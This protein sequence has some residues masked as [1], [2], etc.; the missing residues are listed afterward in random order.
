MP[1]AARLIRIFQPSP[2]GRSVQAMLPSFYK[3]WTAPPESLP[4]IYLLAVRERH[5]PNGEP[6]QWIL[7]ERSETRLDRQDGST[8]TA[9]IRLSFKPL[10]LSEESGFGNHEAFNGNYS[11]GPG[12]HDAEISITGG[13]LMIRDRRL[14][15]KRIG[16]HLMNEVVRWA[17]QWPTAV[18]SE[19]SVSSVDDYLDK[20]D[21]Q[22]GQGIENKLR[23]NL[24]YENFG[25]KMI[26]AD[27]L[28]AEGYSLPMLARELI[29]RD[30]WKQNIEVRDVPGYI[31]ELRN[32]IAAWTQKES[33]RSR[34]IEELE[35]QIKSAKRSPVLW[36]CHQVGL[37][38]CGKAPWIA[39]LGLI[40]L[41]LWV[42]FS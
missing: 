34:H 28:K 40:I 4:R 15:S 7:V 37:R 35:N 10:R 29:P 21:G 22:D 31:R 27:D 1:P 17:Q 13:S 11:S 25:L 41:L 39:L 24:L 20:V 32:D 5:L 18:V 30:T 23:R 9:S 2:V 19:V 3:E 14:Q 38:L 6:V 12:G 42:V 36:A 16:T 8:I 33:E 26:Y